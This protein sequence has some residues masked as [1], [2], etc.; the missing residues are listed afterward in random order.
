M[1]YGIRLYHP[2]DLP[3]LYRICLQTGHN[4]EDAS[5]LYRDPDLPAH[6]YV[7]PYVAYE[8]DL[9]F[10]A[11]VQGAPSGYIL[12]TR[13]TAAFRARCE[14]DWFP[15]LRERYPRPDAAD[16]SL[17]GLIIRNIHR[18][19]MTGPDTTAYPAHLHIDLL[20]V[21]QGQGIGKKLMHT[22]IDRLRNL[23]VPALH[24]GVSK[25]NP[26]AVKFYERFGFHVI[27]EDE[28][29]MLLG[30]ILNA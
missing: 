25:R 27:Q 11:T 5:S 22:F 29:G 24:L 18:G 2:S 20:P 10:V 3:A 7:A 28:D 16:D 30:M 14:Q 6:Y 9:C 4:G 13:D 23:H 1:E 8:P 19:I 12:G 15:A 21:C 26:R 17:D